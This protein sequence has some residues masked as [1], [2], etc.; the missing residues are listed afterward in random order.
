V[1]HKLRGISWLVEDMLASAEGLCCVQL[2]AFDRSLTQLD[3]SAQAVLQAGIRRVS[4]EGTTAV[5]LEVEG[6]WEV[7]PC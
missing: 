6:F 1:F 7:I 3:P 4:V 2:T 5:L